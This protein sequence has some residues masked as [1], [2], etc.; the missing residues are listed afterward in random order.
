M[1]VFKCL[2]AQSGYFAGPV[3]PVRTVTKITEYTELSPAE[4]KAKFRD[5]CRK[6]IGQI[7]SKQYSEKNQEINNTVTDILQDDAFVSRVEEKLNIPGCAAS[8]AVSQA[9]ESLCTAL[10]E[11]KNEYIRSRQDDIRGVAVRLIGMLEGIAD[12]PENCS[13]IT[14]EEISPA[15]ISLIDNQLIGAMLTDKGSPNSHASIIAGNLGIPYLYGSAEAVKAAEKAEFIIIDSETA[16]VI[17]DPPERER[18][19]AEVRMEKVLAERESRLQEEMNFTATCKTKIY[20]N[21]AGPEDLDGLLKSGADGVGL[22]RTEFLFLNTEEAPSEE[23]QYRIYSKVLEAMGDKVVIIRTMDIGSDKKAPWLKLPDENNPALGLRGTR[24]SLEYKDIFRTQLRALLR[25]APGGNLKIMFSMISSQWEVDEI[26]ERIDEVA[27]ELEQEGKNYKVPEIGIMVE[28]PAAAMCAAELAKSVAFF[29]IGTNDLT[30]YT[31]ALDRESRGLDRYF[32]PHHEAVFRMIALTAKGGHENGIETGVCG[33]LGADPEAVKRLIKDG[34]DE[35]SVPI[36]KVRAT[37]I[38]AA[39]AEKELSEETFAVADSACEA[40][41]SMISLTAAA[42]GELFSMEEIPDP[43]FSSGSM[44]K[45]IGIL[46][47]N[48]NI[49]APING[50]VVTVAETHHAV[51]I[52][53]EGGRQIL[54]HVGINTVKLGAKAFTLHV[55]KGSLVEANTLLMETDLEMIKDAGLS[56]MVIVVVLNSP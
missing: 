49:Y 15:L 53:G 32:N 26:K 7:K 23:T 9:A 36:K 19:E 11:V 27:E 8:R 40:G 28:T 47:D 10:G 13:A 6:I 34:V 18:A 29:S 5:A 22:F 16:D 56:T 54:V 48:G 31:L 21:I 41:D 43:V 52:E 46:P 38:L 35:L 12:S 20:A 39:K 44:G 24:V 2:V 50:K 51:V 25:A 37:R 55:E 4:E 17:L 1:E 3:F 33:Q 30:Q 45:C 42:D 14:A